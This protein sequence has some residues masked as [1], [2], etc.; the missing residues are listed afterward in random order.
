MSSNMQDILTSN[1]CDKEIAAAYVD[2]SGQYLVSV[3]VLPLPDQHTATTV[4]NDLSQ[5]SAADFGIWCPD[6][7]T[8]S[9]ACDGDYQSATIKQYREQQHRYIIL[10]VA[11]AVNH[12]QS[13]QI[14]PWLDAAAKKAVDTAGPDN[15]S[16]NQ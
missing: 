2:D 5:Q 6:S 13:T 9:A 3:K 16:G 7:G 10:S 14:T 11:L 4:Y 8:G 12:S 15:W 1:S